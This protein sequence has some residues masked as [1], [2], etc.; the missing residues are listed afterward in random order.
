MLEEYKIKK[1]DNEVILYLYF[2]FNNEF[3]S[4]KFIQKS[5]KIS[6]IVKKFIKNNK[7]FSN[8]TTVVLLS[9]GLIFGSIEV[10]KPNQTTSKPISYEEKISTEE[11]KSNEEKEDNIIYEENDIPS[12]TKEVKNNSNKN[13]DGN[14]VTNK[15][16]SITTTKITKQENK[17]EVKKETVE[18]KTN[19]VV[20]N[21]IYVN[22]KRRNG[23]IINLELEEYIVGVVAAEMPA[24]FNKEALKA[25]ALIARTYALKAISNNKPLTDDV[26]TQSYKNNDELKNMWGNN[27]N[28]YYNKVKSSVNETK[29]KYLTYDGKYIEAVYHSTSNGMTESSV[30]V[31]GNYYPYL[32]SVD[33]TYDSSNPSYIVETTFSY[34]EISQKLNISINSSTLFN[35]TD[36]TSGNRVSNILVDDKSFTGV[37]FR[38]LIGLRSADFLVSNTG[39]NIVIK[40]MGYGH[41]VGMSQYGANGMAK[42][43]SSYIDILKHYYKGVTI[44]NL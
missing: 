41:G 34:E 28:T 12:E 16:T 14:A 37:Q 19:D 39:N 35:I 43:G 6:D 42:N 4:D 22:V 1:V 40:T 18:T 32:V 33:S 23:A 38:N 26:S 25:Q 21:N 3:A 13:T 15:T 9:A 7:I 31:W 30:N 5:E 17:Q 24:S 27:Y 10:Q 20:D 44:N 36:K 29:G 11:L 2:D 8:V